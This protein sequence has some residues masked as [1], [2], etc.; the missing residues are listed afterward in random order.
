MRNQY[1]KSVEAVTGVTI[2]KILIA[3]GLFPEAGMTSPGGYWAR[4][5]GERLP[6]RGSSFYYT[7]SGGVAA[8]NLSD[9]RSYVN[10]N[11]SF[12][13]AFYE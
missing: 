11:V 5:N 7:S 2:P 9:A 10:N 13:S 4:T 3:A 12:R 6:F 1:F 8:L